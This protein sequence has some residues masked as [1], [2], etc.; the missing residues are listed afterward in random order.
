M[1]V[2]WVPV[3]SVCEVYIEYLSQVCV[4][5]GR[6]QRKCDCF[7][8]PLP[9]ATAGE[10][11]RLQRGAGSEMSLPAP[12]CS[13]QSTA[14]GSTGCSKPP[15]QVGWPGAFSSFTSC[16]GPGEATT[17]FGDPGMT[18]EAVAGVWLGKSKTEIHETPP[19]SWLILLGCIKPKT[20][21]QTRRGR[22]SKITACAP[23]SQHQ[24]LKL[25]SHS[26]PTFQC[27]P[28]AGY[29]ISSRKKAT[30]QK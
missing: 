30:T 24:H 15:H 4:K 29:L 14:L 17:A 8:V 7:P 23:G 28:I 21:A 11:L 22:H 12:V 25:H 3:T 19:W 18:M 5:L 1:S 9:K 6:I 16:Y 10:C 20:T 13:Y 26:S 27:S 2:H